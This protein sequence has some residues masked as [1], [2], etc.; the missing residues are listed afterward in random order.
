MASK[1]TN[2]G[3]SKQPNKIEEVPVGVYAYDLAIIEDL[4][5]RFNHTKDGKQKTNNIIQITNAENVF[6]IIGDIQN[7]NIQFP[8]ISLVRTGWQIEDYSQEFMNNSGGLV[9]YLEDEPGSRVR[10]VRLQAIPI[11]I[12]Y[13]LDIWTQNRLDN[14][15]IAREFIWFYKQ[16][17]Q[18]RVKIPHGLNITHPFNIGIENEIV[19]NSDIAEHNSRG[20]YYRQTLGLYTDKD[21]YLWK[22]S[23]TNVPMIDLE[24]YSIYE[25]NI[26]EL[27]KPIEEDNNLI[28]PEEIFIKPINYSNKEEN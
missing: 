5:A 7:D 25:G 2:E 1:N 12:N 27:D 14:D 17:P 4:R 26:N 18:M 21:A 23:V 22:S 15:I 3:L 24:K 13:Q 28:I 8:I 11:Q 9:G 6:N 16:N 19:D 20:R 10:Q